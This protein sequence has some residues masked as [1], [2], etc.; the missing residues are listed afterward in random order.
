MNSRAAHLPADQAVRHKPYL[1]QLLAAVRLDVDYHRGAGAQ[2]FFRDSESQ[3]EHEVLDLV[4]GFGSLLL[5]HHPPEL[6]A[7]AQRLLLAGIPFHA[8]GSAQAS[9]ERLAQVLARR[10]GGDYCCVFA[11]SGTE[12]VEA[13]LKHALLETGGRTLLAVEGAFHGKTL[14][15]LQAIGNPE[16]REPFELAGLR[17]LRVR[18]N[19]TDSLARAFAEADDLAGFLCE[20]IL[21]EGGVRPLTAAFLQRAAA[22]CAERHVPFMADECQTGC[23]RTGSF[24]ACAELGVQPDYVVLSKALGGGLAKIGATLIRR[25]RYQPAFDRKHTSTFAADHFSCAIALRTLDLLDEAR[26]DQV[27]ELGAEWLHA[28]RQLQRAFPDVLSDVRGRGLML[29]VEFQPQ[30]ASASFLLRLLSSQRDLLHVVAGYLLHRHGVRVLPTLSDPWTLRLQPPVCVTATDLKRT[31][32]ALE[33]VCLRLRAHDLPSLAEFLLERAPPSTAELIPPPTRQ[34]LFCFDAPAFHQQQARIPP[35][36]VAWLCHMIDADDLTRQEP[37]LSA[38]PYEQREQLLAQCSPFAC[39]VVM[40]AVDVTASTGEVVR[41]YPIMLPFSSRMAKQALDARRLGWFRSLI[42]RGVDTARELDCSLVSLGQYTSILMRNGRSLADVTDLGLTS[43]NSYTVALALEAIERL[44]EDRGTTA[45]TLTLAIVGASGNIGRTCAA[46]LAPRFGRTLLVGSE[47]S[48]SRTRLE[49][50]AR[51]LPQ[52]VVA[53]SADLR[54]AQVIVSAVNA[55]NAPLGPGQLGPGAIVCDISV[56]SSV[57][58]NTAALRPDVTLLKGGLAR[59]PHGEDLHIAS[60]PLPPGQSFGCLAEALLLG[61]AGERDH[62]GTGPVTPQKV[63]HLAQL[64]AQFGFELAGYKRACVLG[65]E[66]RTEGLH[67]SG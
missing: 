7:E 23:G 42:R 38:L 28:L 19:D 66:Q 67:V 55:V 59:L 37:C 17:V 32:R 43:G 29:G 63:R 57:A 33:D 52:A 11:N 18:A 64:A 4:S 15:A 31:L 48:H 20:P 62:R 21:G 51:R 1:Q 54:D 3:P 27:R 45:A 14:G 40:S 34:P 39:P 8:Q 12:A 50:L 13:A 26:L 46:L 24:L 6:V 10:A 30:S 56:P 49:R 60:F 22:C 35:R 58:A 9:A 2:L 25:S 41:L 53:T 47:Q 61:L 36:R 65:S 44:L 16:Y 5:G